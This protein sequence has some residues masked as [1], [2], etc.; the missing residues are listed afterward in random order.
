[1]TWGAPKHLWDLLIGSSPVEETPETQYPAVILAQTISEPLDELGEKTSGRIF[2][3]TSLLA[4]SK[5]AAVLV[6]Q[7]SLSSTARIKPYSIVSEGA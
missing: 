6:G 3:L 4:P 7:L 1:V 2:C 5:V